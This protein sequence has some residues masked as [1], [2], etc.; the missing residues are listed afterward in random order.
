MAGLLGFLA[1]GAARQN[2]AVRNQETETRNR[3]GAMVIQQEMQEMYQARRDERMAARE[4][5]VY[6]RGR[7]DKLADEG[8][9]RE[10]KK[11]DFQMGAE[12]DLKKLEVQHGHDRSLEGMRQAGAEKR[13]NIRAQGLLNTG[14]SRKS[15]DN[16][17]NKELAKANESDQKRIFDLK[18]KMRSPLVPGNAEQNKLME[19]EIKRLQFNII[20]REALMKYGDVPVDLSI[21]LKR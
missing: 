10:Y 8:R 18:K 2:A 13:A 4:E 7:T 19:E 12:H 17:S 5:A 6:Q 21:I 15:G 9:E 14:R 11:Q 16:F 20:D 3:I 1:A